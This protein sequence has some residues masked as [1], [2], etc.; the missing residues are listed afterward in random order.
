MKLVLELPEPIVYWLRDRCQAHLKETAKK[1]KEDYYY[2]PEAI[3]IYK[4][5]LKAIGK[6]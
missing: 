1:S 5:V 2:A 4:A 6:L 3:E